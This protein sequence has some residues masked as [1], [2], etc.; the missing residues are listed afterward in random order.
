MEDA[1][2]KNTRSSAGSLNK[3]SY[4]QGEQEVSEPPVFED[5]LLQSTPKTNSDKR[6]R[7]RTPSGHVLTNS[8][9]DIWNFFNQKSM[10]QQTNSLTY[11]YR[12]NSPVNRSVNANSRGRRPKKAP[13]C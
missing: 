7:N 13:I 4:G 2:Y 1:P 5:K 3:S 12:K 9:G 11:D 8:V 10:E 6:I